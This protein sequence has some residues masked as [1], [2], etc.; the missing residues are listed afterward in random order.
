VPDSAPAEVVTGYINA[1]ERAEKALEADLPKYLPLWEMAVPPEFAN[2]KWD[3][4]K[5]GRGEKF[6][7]QPLAQKD[8]DEVFNQV[9][10]WGLDQFV[11]DKKIESLSYTA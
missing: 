5:F 11:K 8:F 4:S 7:R 3:Y 2:Q 9:E 10:R 1:L 6:V